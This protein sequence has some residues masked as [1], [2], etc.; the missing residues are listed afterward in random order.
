MSRLR[1]L[2]VLLLLLFGS[3]APLQANDERPNILF[4]IADLSLIHI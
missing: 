1:L 3:A 4:A 2:P